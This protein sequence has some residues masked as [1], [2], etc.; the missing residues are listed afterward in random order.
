MQLVVPFQNFEISLIFKTSSIDTVFL[1]TLGTSIPIVPLPG[2]GAIILIPSAARLNEISSSR[3]LILDI[4]T[5][6]QEQ[7]HTVLL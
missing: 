7:F 2:M 3:F 4:L 1:F 6:H 5:Q